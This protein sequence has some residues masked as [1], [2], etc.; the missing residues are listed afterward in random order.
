MVLTKKRLAIFSALL[1]IIYFAL[2]MGFS[3]QIGGNR[4]DGAFL[5]AAKTA[6]I[7]LSAAMATSI[8]I[9]LTFKRDF[10]RWQAF[11]FNRFKY[12]LMMKVKRDFIARYRKSVLGVLWSL[13][14]PLLTMI[15]MTI[16]FS[17]VFENNIPNFPVYLFAG[18]VI[19]NFFS[20]STSQAMSSIIGN[21][22][23]IR[24]IYVP[25]Y[26]FPLTRV[27]SS[28][29]N[30][31]FGV[32]AMFIV[33]AATG[34]PFYWTMLLIPIPIFF[35]FV[36]ALGLSLMLSALTVYFRDLAYL[37]GVTL[38]LLQFMSALFWPIDILPESVR[39]FI[40][41]NP[42]FQ[43]ISYM[44]SLVL[45]GVVPDLWTNLVCASLALVSLCVGTYVFITKQERF[46]LYM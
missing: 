13:L 27:I 3:E 31:A 45:D 35:T 16:I 28:L 4:G 1:S 10:L 9:M 17:T 41:L 6:F 33:V 11:S 2:F 20:E 23:I 44:R 8:V 39:P 25:K 38:T 29:I 37:W 19:F 12:F 7:S 22:G 5:H 18:L 36:F 40:G 34:A 14:N 24:R 46:I 43:F 32:V 26:I 21:E 30:M 42:V 15:I